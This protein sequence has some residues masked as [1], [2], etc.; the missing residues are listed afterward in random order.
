MVENHE[1]VGHGLKGPHWERGVGTN[2]E[3]P[4]DFVPL[5]LEL[6]SLEIPP[7]R[8]RLEVSLQAV[9]VGRH[10]EADI[11]VAYPDVSRRHCRLAFQDGYWHIVDLNSLNG[12]FVNGERIHEAV[13][14]E[15]DLIRLGSVIM[16]VQSRAQRPRTRSRACCAA[17]P[18]I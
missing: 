15:G 17:L 4:A 14:L 11:R 8:E 12:L 1:E 6:Q 16:E 13:L 3:L 18:T 10:S 5:R 9:V 2:G 7:Q